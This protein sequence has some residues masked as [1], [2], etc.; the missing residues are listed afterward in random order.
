VPV[1]KTFAKVLTEHLSMN[2]FGKPS[3]RAKFGVGIR[4]TGPPDNSAEDV[5]GEWSAFGTVMMR[6]R[7][8]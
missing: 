8:R 2:R 4:H 7:C 6:V 3:R 1:V 5:L